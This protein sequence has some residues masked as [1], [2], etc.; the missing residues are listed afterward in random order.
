[1]VQIV[2]VTRTYGGD[3]GYRVKAGTKFSVAKPYKLHGVDLQVISQGR[4]SQLLKANLIRTYAGDN[5]PLSETPRPNYEGQASRMTTVKQPMQTQTRTAAQAR[6]AAPQEP[7]PLE[8]PASPPGGQTGAD[9][10]SSSSAA[11]QASKPSTSN[12]RGNRTSKP[13]PSTIRTKSA[14]GPK[15]STPATGSGGVSIKD[16]NPSKD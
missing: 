5:T 2:E 6:E 8:N 14:R 11:A 13:S 10:S 9:S 1:M 4:Y 3:E 7:R 16:A 15:P 12:V